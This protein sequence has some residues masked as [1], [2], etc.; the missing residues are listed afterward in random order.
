ML[1]HGLPGPWDG[2]R[3]SL[4]GSVTVMGATDGATA[5]GGR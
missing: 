3:L 2:R 1:W 5:A 4:G